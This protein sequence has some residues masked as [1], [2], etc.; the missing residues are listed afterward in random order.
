MLLYK[1]FDRKKTMREKRSNDSFESCFLSVMKVVLILKKLHS[2]KN[3]CSG[4]ANHLSPL[5]LVR[6]SW[7][8]TVRLD[9]WGSFL[10]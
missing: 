1:S 6:Y 2:F 3:G 8:G 4:E 10:L 7:I 9:F 5:H